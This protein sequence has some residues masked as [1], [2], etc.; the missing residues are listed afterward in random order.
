MNLTEIV[1]HLEADTWLSFWHILPEVVL[2]CTILLMLVLRVFD[3]TRKIDPFFVALLGALAALVLGAP[4]QH[5]GDQR[6]EI[7]TGMHEVA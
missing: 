5:I 1:Q 6:L 4:W 7:F 2:L 3:A